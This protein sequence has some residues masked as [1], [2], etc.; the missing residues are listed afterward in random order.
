MSTP[1]N[2]V[3]LLGRARSTW[4]NRPFIGTRQPDGAYT[5]T[6]YAAFA[7]RVDRVR[8][9]LA[10]LG[11][12][13]GTAVGFIG[14]NREE[15]A[16]AAFATFGLAARFVP[17]YEAELPRIWRHILRDSGARVV[18]VATE[19]IRDQLAELDVELDHVVVLEGDGSGTLA[20]LEG[21]EPPPVDAMDP[22]P[23][24][25][26]VLIYTSGTTSDPKGVLLT[27]DNMTKNVL[28][29]G[30]LY[31]MLDEHG[32]F[33][34]IL[35]WAHS[36]AQVADLYNSMRV[37]A[38]LAV[39][40][41]VDTLVGD[42][43]TV[44]PTF[45]VVVPRL[46]TKIH[47]GMTAKFAAM[48]PVGRAL[49][50]SALRA[51][52]AVRRGEAGPVTRAWHRLTDKVLL[53]KV[54]ARLGGRLAGMLSGSAALDPEVMEFFHDLGL[55]TYDAYGLTETSPAVT[56]NCPAAWRAGSV[57][58]PIDG[59]RVVIDRS[60][61]EGDSDDGEIVVYGHNVMAGYHNLPEKTAEV[62]TDDGGFRT[63]DR[64]RLDADGFLYV[65][66]RIKEQYK[67]QNGKYVF[68]AGVEEAMKRSPRILSAMLVGVG[69]THNIALVVPEPEPLL[70]W[71]R[72]QGLPAELSALVDEPRAEAWLLEAAVAELSDV[73]S[74]ERPKRVLIVTEDFSRE[75][76]TLTQTLK[77]KRRVVLEL[78][79]DRVE[80]AYRA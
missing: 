60:V 63:G 4:G 66:G 17:M 23:S 58:R 76:G 13:A 47:A 44:R 38:G 61:I 12:T 31:P 56:M 78:Y 2:L 53:A 52:R 8:A 28:H 36:F 71:A 50:A 54:R 1:Q 6:T 51:S 65:T 16:V 27:H 46:L 19:A 80:A 68:P 48:G 26:A 43:A 7:G 42:I 14:N 79:G 9:G 10:S 3:Q 59:V 32:V 5:W 40:G 55:P 70:A 57:G 20:A 69:R 34:S 35:P 15:W 18:L 37:G 29:G 22:D 45:M 77:L 24:D 25:I 75:A 39:A 73:A 49:I 41:G 72:E 30:G 21:A 74:Y 67:L 62:M 64:G 11:V 33:L